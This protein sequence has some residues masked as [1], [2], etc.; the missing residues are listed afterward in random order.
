MQNP[1]GPGKGIIAEMNLI[2]LIDVSLILLIIFMVMTPVLVQ[3]QFSVKLPKAKEGSPAPQTNL[4]TVTVEKDGRIVIEG[5]KIRDKDLEKELILR[6][7]KSAEKTI[8]VQADKTVPIEKVVL[9]LDI[10]RKLG[11]SKLGIG[12]TP[13]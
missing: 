1:I 9:V 13:Y 6:L 2:P 7:P 4:L 3:S 11:V 10:S 5:R 12:V 8:L